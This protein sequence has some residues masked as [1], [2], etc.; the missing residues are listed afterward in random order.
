VGGKWLAPAND[1]AKAMLIQAEADILHARLVM[2]ADE[3]VGCTEGSPEEQELASIT[4][5]IEAYETVRWPT[6]KAPGG[7]G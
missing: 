4:D 7:K 6:G 1:V 2:R 5:A 3:L